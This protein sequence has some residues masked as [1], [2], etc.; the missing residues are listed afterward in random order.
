MPLRCSAN[1]RPGSRSS[2]SKFPEDE[3]DRQSTSSGSD[4][5][6]PERREGSTEP[7]DLGQI[8]A[9]VVVEPKRTQQ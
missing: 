5:P 3:A 1:G 9:E 8:T 4:Q 2:A 7:E 6:R